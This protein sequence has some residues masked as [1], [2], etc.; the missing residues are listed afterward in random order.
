MS[1][2]R[3]DDGHDPVFYGK[4]S[5]KAER[6]HRP[7]TSRVVCITGATFDASIPFVLTFL[8]MPLFWLFLFS[9]YWAQVYLVQ[10]GVSPGS[11]IAN[12][13]FFWTA[14]FVALFTVYYIMVFGFTALCPVIG[15]RVFP[16]I[17]LSGSA[18]ATLPLLMWMLAPMFSRELLMTP[19][20]WFQGLMLDLTCFEMGTAFFAHYFA[21]RAWARLAQGEAFAEGPAMAIEPMPPAELKPSS[22]EWTIPLGG[23]L[24]QARNILRI[25][26]ADHYVTVHFQD[27][28]T[29]MV[30]QNIGPIA[31]LLPESLGCMIHRSHWVA[32][33]A[34]SR[35]RTSAQVT[36]LILND[37]TRLPVARGRKVEVRN[38]LAEMGLL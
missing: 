33:N 36:E 29:R 23:S 30:R 31:Q 11:G 28:G 24:V 1:F 8:R 2:V 6:V 25:E 37:G 21:P 5:Y 34:V 3:F 26:A 17:L 13:F 32:G 22:Q 9:S 12:K 20:Q 4:P 35:M 10:A 19:S 14:L 16:H 18:V 7:G 38:W 27:G 15:I